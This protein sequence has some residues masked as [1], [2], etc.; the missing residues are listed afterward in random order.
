MYM[1][2]LTN[3][4]TSYIFAR[5]EVH[6]YYGKKMIPDPRANWIIEG[7][8]GETQEGNDAEAAKPQQWRDVGE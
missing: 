5:K 6:P 8:D 3:G 1:E 2:R 4:P 7:D